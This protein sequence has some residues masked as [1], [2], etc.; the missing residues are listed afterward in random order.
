M[1]SKWKS[2]AKDESMLDVS[3]RIKFLSRNEDLCQR[4]KQN[5]QLLASTFVV[6]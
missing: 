4:R 1:I 2:E 5:L 6:S 3:F